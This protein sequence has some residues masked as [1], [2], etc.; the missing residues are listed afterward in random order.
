MIIPASALLTE[1]FQRGAYG[2]QGEG[3]EVP[4]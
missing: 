2:G 1:D 3:L 4:R